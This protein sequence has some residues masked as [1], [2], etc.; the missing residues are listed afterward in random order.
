MTATPILKD[1]PRLIA[2]LKTLAVSV[3][4]A[5]LA[6][7]FPFAGA[8]IQQQ[9][10]AAHWQDLASRYLEAEDALDWAAPGSLQLAALRVDANPET[11]VTRVAS[12][13]L[14]ELRTFD[15]THIERARLEAE[16]LD[17]L[18]T[19][20][21]YEA[22]GEGFAGQTAVAEVVMN[23]VSHP[24]YPDTV[25]GVVYEGST[26]ATGC[27]F[28]FTCDGSINRAP[29]GRAWRRAQ[30][31]AEHVMLGFAP[32]VTRNATHYHTVAIDPHWSSSLVRTRTIGEHIFYRFPSRRE[33]AEMERDL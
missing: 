22:R 14:A 13:P 9:E 3:L 29:R 28:S 26:R 30:L 21:Y 17:C 15:R 18:A 4:A 11:G 2:G 7:M 27:Q 6:A 31:V 10:D 12:R 20:V 23:R 5:S 19:A 24:A 32:P 33:R 8:R 16:Q 1:R 25:C